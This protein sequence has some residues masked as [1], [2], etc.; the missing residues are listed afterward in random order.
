[1]ATIVGQN[2]WV[3]PKIK[4]DYCLLMKTFIDMSFTMVMQQYIKLSKPP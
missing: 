2:I 4:A 3:A 1:M